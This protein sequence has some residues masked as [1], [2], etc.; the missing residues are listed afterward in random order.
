ML[1][2]SFLGHFYSPIYFFL[3]INILYI[4]AFS[5]KHFVFSEN[6]MKISSNQAKNIYG[7]DMVKIYKCIDGK[8]PSAMHCR[9]IYQ[10]LVIRR[11][12]R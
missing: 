1:V 4:Q 6:H 5:L 11:D 2:K 3:Y 8:Q 7:C 10:S 12:I 9:D